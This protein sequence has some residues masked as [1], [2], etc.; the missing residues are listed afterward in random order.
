VNHWRWDTWHRTFIRSHRENCAYRRY[1]RWYGPALL[2]V[3]LS[4][5][6]VCWLEAGV[7]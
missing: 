6:A 1:P 2:L 3:L 4:W 5:L 7:A